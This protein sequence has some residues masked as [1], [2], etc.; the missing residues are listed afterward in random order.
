[1]VLID[2][3]V[4][5]E[6]FQRG[7]KELIEEIN[8]LLDFGNVAIC[9]VILGELLAG[10]KDTDFQSKIIHLKD[11]C[12]VIGDDVNNDWI[13]AG[14]LSKKIQKKGKKVGLLDCYLAHIA[15][16]NE[17]SLWSYDKDFKFISENSNLKLK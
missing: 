7:A 1:M 13:K 3:S 15:I 10:A 2:T 14:I 4:W 6:Y 8:S 12:M 17:I 5:I 11:V 16:K 9:G